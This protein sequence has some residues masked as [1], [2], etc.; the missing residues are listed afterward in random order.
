MKE[1][2]PGIRNEEN[3]ELEKVKK[4]KFSLNRFATNHSTNS[5]FDLRVTDLDIR[6]SYFCF[7]NNFIWAADQ[8]NGLIHKI[9]VVAKVKGPLMSMKAQGSFDCINFKDVNLEAFKAAVALWKELPPEEKELWDDYE[10]ED[11]NLK[12]SW[13]AELSGYHK[14]IKANVEIIMKNNIDKNVRCNTIN[15]E[16]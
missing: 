1:Y 10:D 2:L 6:L 15:I 11:E 13:Q 12:N 14:M 4:E 5:F 8:E 3:F 9:K 16:N 7:Q